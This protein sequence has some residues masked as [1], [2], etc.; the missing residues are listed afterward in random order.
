MENASKALVIA[1]AILIVILLISI[2][3]AI[4]NSTSN[5]QKEVNEGIESTEV[6]SFNEQF[7]KF[8]GRIVNASQV[9]S[10]LL[11]T[12]ANNAYYDFDSNTPIGTDKYVKIT[13][14]VTSNSLFANKTYKVSIDSYN[15]NGYVSIIKI[16]L[17]S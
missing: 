8:E 12:K 15:Q 14:S 5:L 17:N 16:E 7:T 11:L 1:G 6:Q 9:K 3:I 2:G 13:G 4:L 10:L